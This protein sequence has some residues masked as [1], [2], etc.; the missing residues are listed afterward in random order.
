VCIN[1][2]QIIVES[3][4]IR[5]IVFSSIFTNRFVNLVIPSKKKKSEI[6]EKNNKITKNVRFIFFSLHI[7][8]AFFCNRYDS[9]LLAF[10]LFFMALLVDIRNL[11]RIQ[12]LQAYP[13]RPSSDTHDQI[14]KI[15]LKTTTAK[16]TTFN[17]KS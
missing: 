1:R 4:F 9:A 7:V 13:G 14:L 3:F 10:I 15:T 5:R 6:I 8:L 2:N 12:R 11:K 17:Q 16:T